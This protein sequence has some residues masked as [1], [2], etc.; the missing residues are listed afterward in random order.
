MKITNTAKKDG[1]PDLE[2]LAEM[3]ALGTEHAIKRQEAQGQSEVVNCA[4]LPSDGI[5]QVRQM[6]ES[7]G[8]SIGEVVDGDPMFTNVTLPEGWKKNG[9]DHAMWTKLIDDKGRERASIFYKAAFYDRSAHINPHRRFSI[10]A[11][12]HDVE[13]EVKVSLTDAMG[14][15][16]FST[17]T[18]SVKDGERDYD[19]RERLRHEVQAYLYG[20]FPNWE[21]CNAYWD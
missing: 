20:N 15:V 17:A 19:I 4:V 18:V 1:Q 12:S 3:M 8:G 16:E 10:D 14:E 13:G 5:E 6:I 11:Y 21:D 9:S 2:M 7:N